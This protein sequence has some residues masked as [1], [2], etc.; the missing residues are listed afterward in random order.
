MNKEQDILFS[1]LAAAVRSQM[2]L[3]GDV[4]SEQWKEV[5]HLANVNAVVALTFEAI[6]KLPKEKMPPQN[7][8]MMW[9][10]IAEQKKEHNRRCL[11]VLSEVICVFEANE[12]KYAVLKGLGVANDYPDFVLRDGGDIDLLIPTCDERADELLLKMGG[13]ITSEMGF[14]LG[15]TYKGVYL[16][17]HHTPTHYKK[18][19]DYLKSIYEFENV[20]IGGVN[21]VIPTPQFMILHLL[22]HIDVHIKAGGIGLR[23]IT[24]LYFFFTKHIEKYDKEILQQGIKKLG[25]EPISRFLMWVLSSKYGLEDALL[26]LPPYENRYSNIFLEN[27]VKGGNFGVNADIITDVDRSQCF[28][29]RKT[30]AAM[31]LFR[32][33]ILLRKIE[34]KI[35][36]LFIINPIISKIFP[37]NKKILR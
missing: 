12:V 14:R 22:L 37:T 6:S 16:Q 9:L 28:F 2:P 18:R 27:V 19:N 10:A 21:V 36:F 8:F 17:I 5:F 23:H 34:V 31:I 29:K 11:E 33:A 30:K 32:R 7:V 26:P 3:L 1:L 15:I 13:K 4:S 20:N 25:L 35:S 24:D